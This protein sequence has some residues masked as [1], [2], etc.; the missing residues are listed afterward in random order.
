MKRLSLT[1]IT[2]LVASSAVAC[3][4]AGDDEAEPKTVTRLVYAVPAP[5]QEAMNPNRDLAPGDEYQLKP[6]YE[7]LIGSDPQ[8]GNWVPMLA[9]SWQLDGDVLTFVLR[10]G[11]QFHNDKGEFTAADVEYSYR[12]LVEPA[13]AIS[14]VAE[15]MR[16]A[17]DRIEIVDPYRIAFHLK[18][19]SYAF[20][21]GLGYG[22][23]GMA[24]KSKADGES[25]S[26]ALTLK[27]QPVAGTGP[28]QFLERT[29]GQN[30]IFKKIPYEHWRQNAG[31]P[32]LE[33][34]YINENATRMS[35]LLA[36]EVHLTALPDE[37]T[38]EAANQGA[39]V[40]RASVPG[41]RIGVNL[42][43]CY[44]KEPP[45]PDE[46]SAQVYVSN[47]RKF[48]D[49]PICDVRVRRAINKAIDRDALNKAFYGGK[50]EQMVMW[51]WQPELP[52]FNPAW[53]QRWQEVYGF[54]L[55]A[56]KALIAEAGY[57]PG[58]LKIEVAAIPDSG[59]PESED[60][61][62]AIAGMLADAGFDT[63]IVSLDYQRQKAGREARE[64]TARLEFDSTSSEP[65]TGF[66][67]QGYANQDSGRA[68]EEIALDSAYEPI[69]RELD[70]AKQAVLWQ[71]F[72]DQVFEAV[73]HVPLLRIRDEVVADPAVV[74]SYT[75]PGAMNS[76]RYSFVEYITPAAS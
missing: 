43:G 72:G 16:A 40:I 13:G 22:A 4:S 69:L 5:A 50:A 20:M 48:P 34:R 38:A 49:S 76:E 36:G 9:E 73:Q 1:L 39:K 25:R 11:V 55:E 60:V 70:P 42:L 75:F 74:G 27:D 59:G 65:I 71:S 37:L 17:V 26:G 18:E 32:E 56:A 7:N 3:T 10:K 52:G 57:Q 67:P 24:I 47:E 14:G 45:S 12:D 35:A 66:E 2:V 53:Q 29:P 15:A 41:R 63:P 68:V 46:K 58:Q 33:L 23:I 28:Y 61:G 8:T 51:Y 64:Y 30:V 62:E 54:D 19:T 21:E 31:F 44:Y 6:I